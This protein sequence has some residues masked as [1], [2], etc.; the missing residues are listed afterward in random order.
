MN[1]FNVEKAKMRNK[2]KCYS[3]TLIAGAV[4]LLVSSC[5]IGGG[6]G[7][8]TEVE[9]PKLGPLESPF[10]EIIPSAKELMLLGT[11]VNEETIYYP[12][13]SIG[14]HRM[15]ANEAANRIDKVEGQVPLIFSMLICDY[16]DEE[17]ARQRIQKESKK[18][19]YDEYSTVRDAELF[20][21]SLEDIAV[22]IVFF[23]EPA[24][25]GV[26]GE[27]TIFF[28]VG[29]YVGAYE[30]HVGDPPEL[31]DGFFMPPQMTDRLELAVSKTIPKLRS[32]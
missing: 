13:G 25:E 3:I 12:D 14:Y 9:E 29:R 10:S 16:L 26:Q 30:V 23:K 8:K 19:Q 1:V 28:R 4:L 15:F 20:G 5:L 18:P 11:V 31:A 17:Q 24:V 27:E 2:S 22:H 21:L 7:H 32:L 6:C